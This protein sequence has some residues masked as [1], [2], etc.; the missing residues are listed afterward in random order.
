MHHAYEQ[1]YAS[2]DKLVR[3]ARETMKALARE[4]RQ[5]ISD[6]PEMESLMMSLA[7]PIGPVRGKKKY[8]YLPRR[9]K[10]TVDEIVDQMER[11]P[12]IDKYYQV[13]WGFQCQIGD[14]YSEK[15]RQ[16]PPI[17]EQKEFRS[18]KNAVIQEAENI[19]MG[20]ATFEDTGV[21]EEIEADVL[22]ALP[23]DCWELW[24]VI[25]DDTALMGDRDEAAAQLM[26]MAESGDPE[27]QYLVGKLYQDG[28]VL[29][30]DSVAARYW[31]D[32]SARQGHV[33]AQYELGKLLPCD[34]PKVCDPALGIQWLEYAA[35]NGNNYAAYRLGKEYLRGK[36]VE[37][38]TVKVMDYLAQSAEA[39]N[40]YAQ[41]ALGKLYLDR[42]KQGQA[43][44]WF[45]QSASQGNEHAQFF[46]DRW[47]SL[48]SPSV[49]LSVTRLLYHMGTV[50]REQAPAPSVPGGIQIDRK[51]L[52]QLKEKKIA[53]GHKADDH[54]DLSQGWTMTMG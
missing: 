45:T 41:Y 33:A 37:K 47:D 8:G 50:F 40:Q 23:Y 16:R 7:N 54:E 3:Q 36:I 20:M 28:P 31:F 48:R 18:I 1:K 2:R 32:L 21:A 11:L 17:S 25:Q 27:A 35:S 19:R 38:D 4:M 10:K 15:K 42:Q 49:M 26:E 13:W 9:V 29:I 5:S 6:H 22:S 14:F 24:L 43:Y 30:P 52:A 51:R 53:M 34:D 44:Y 39:G 12:V 46:L